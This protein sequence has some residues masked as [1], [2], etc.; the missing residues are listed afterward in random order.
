M[1]E[2]Q[3]TDKVVVFERSQ[4]IDV[5]SGTGDDSFRPIPDE[6]GQQQQSLERVNL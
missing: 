6:I 3:L 1:R 4:V 2:K 5:F